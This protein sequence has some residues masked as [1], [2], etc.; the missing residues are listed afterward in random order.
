MTSSIVRRGFSALA[1][2]AATAASIGAVVIGAGSAAAVEAD[3]DGCLARQTFPMDGGGTL[4]VC[5]TAARPTC[6]SWVNGTAAAVGGTVVQ[7]TCGHVE[8]GQGR[9][10]HPAGF[11]GAV[12]RPK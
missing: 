9:W 12:I 4:Y 6:V 8:Q 11:Y 10:N 2:A 5:V 7:G 3:G 1:V